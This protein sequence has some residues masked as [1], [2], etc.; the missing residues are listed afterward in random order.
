MSLTK[1]HNDSQIRRHLTD[2]AWFEAAAWP[3]WIKPVSIPLRVATA[4]HTILS[5]T[6]WQN[7]CWDG[8]KSRT[9]L[10]STKTQLHCRQFYRCS[11]LA[12]EFTVKEMSWARSGRRPSFA[13]SETFASL[14]SS[15]FMSS[16]QMRQRRVPPRVKHSTWLVGWWWSVVN[17][18]VIPF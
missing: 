15:L 10:T 11:Q 2:I 14:S 1:T 6:L 13:S 5:L 9:S 3:A 16:L 12:A 18:S 7:Q 4:S 8:F 17:I